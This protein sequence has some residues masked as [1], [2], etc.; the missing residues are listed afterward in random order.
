MKDTPQPATPLD[1]EL[2]GETV[3]AHGYTVT[4]TARVRGKL[5]STQ[6]D[7][8][9]GTWGWAA[10]RP[11]KITV[12]DREGQ[13]REIALPNAEARALISMAVIGLIVALASLLIPLLVRR[14][15]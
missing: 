12:G 10:I 9:S 2:T 5:G 13:T 3:E 4:P 8:Q 7:E 11:V 1:L 15:E 6:K 14:R